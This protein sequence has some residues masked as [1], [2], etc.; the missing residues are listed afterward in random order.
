M[1]KR[2]TH[3]RLLSAARAAFALTLLLVL[4][5]AQALA[6]R[7][8][9]AS[10]AGRVREGERGVAGV[11]VV[12]MSA[13]SSQRFKPAG[14]A[15]TDA[16]GRYRV[17]GLP[18]G[19][20][21]VTP[22]A[23]AFVLLDVSSFPPG[24]PLTLSAGDSV[25]DTDFRVIRGG[26]ITGRV[27]DSDGNPVVMEPVRITP[28][29]PKDAQPRSRF[30]GVDERDLSTDDRGVYR[31]Y[32]IQP[33]RYRVSV[34]GNGRTLRAPGAKYYRRTFHPSA[35][36][37]SQAKVVDVTA[38]AEAGDVD[39][40]LGPPEKT[41]RASGRFV[42]ADTNQPAPVSA[43]GYGMLDPAS[44]S[45]LGEYMGGSANARGEFQATGLAPGRYKLFASPVPQETVDWY[46]DT[47]SFEITDSDLSGLVVKLRRGSTVS[48]VVA[49][50]GLRDRA[51]A[52]R[53]LTGVR[54][55]GAAT[56]R[57]EGDDTGPAGF[58]RPVPVGPDGSFQITG[59]RP[60]RF[61]LDASTSEVKGLAFSRVEVG[62]AE[63]R[64]GITVAEGA[65]VTGV[66]VVLVYGTATLR[67][68]VSVAAGSALPQG[69]RTFVVVRR[70]GGPETRFT[71]G[72]EADVRGLFQ[73]EGLPAGE[74]EVQARSFV[75]DRPPL[76]SE[77]ARVSVGE[78]GDVTINL[79]LAQ[80]LNAPA[81]PE[82][83]EQ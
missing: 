19:K 73:I 31:V 51:A 10:V 74:Y 75:P 78:G 30:F 37:E 27:T 47:L 57:G 56:Q 59:V 28:E 39:I 76:A 29:D 6:Q 23:P 16:E 8:A 62:G 12:V 54:V 72:A 43:F 61:R 24:K 25:E 22:M 40:T 38:G 79:T 49:I 5:A 68:Q 41:F 2:Q 69:A 81:P 60:G 64:D 9:P 55:Y 63:Q 32:G 13:E 7:E 66:R 82:V 52:A 44:G 80:R 67:G 17:A 71:K 48:G 45:P 4:C 36:D 53:M 26:V 42:Y 35:T 18:P 70:V 14:R 65:Q 21:V 20:Y 3:G 83:R 46:S 15:R 34:G 1:P 11:N 77:S 58:M 50:E 33:G